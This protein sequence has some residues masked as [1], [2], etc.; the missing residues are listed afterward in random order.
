MYICINIID[1]I[2]KKYVFSW[3]VNQI[4]VSWLMRLLENWWCLA[5]T[6]LGALWSSWKCKPG[7]S[8][9]N[10]RNSMWKMSDFDACQDC[11]FPCS[12]V[13]ARSFLI[14]HP[15]A[16]EPRDLEKS[17]VINHEFLNFLNFFLKN[18]N[19]LIWLRAVSC[20]ADHAAS[21]RTRGKPLKGIPH[22]ELRKGLE[23]VSRVLIPHT[24]QALVF[25]RATPAIGA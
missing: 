1:Q 16:A 23:F 18:E 22:D 2:Q 7:P 11:A 13:F 6:C 3:R 14:M 25:L 12:L 9:T 20:H 5:F 4:V 19:D 15:Q 8:M 24:M 21:Y 10:V 17:M